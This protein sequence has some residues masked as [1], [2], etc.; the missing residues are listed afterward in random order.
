LESDYK[1][2]K[3]SFD[4]TTAPYDKWKDKLENDI[5]KFF[6]YEHY[7][8]PVYAK[9][10]KGKEILTEIEGWNKNELQ[11]ID[12]YKTQ[13]EAINKVYNDNVKTG[14]LD[15][16]SSWATADT[17]RTKYAAEATDVLLHDNLRDGGLLY[18]NVEGIV[19]LGHSSEETKVYVNNKEYPVA[20]DHN[21]DGTPTSGYDVL[22]ITVEGTD[23]KAIY[24]FAFTV[25]PAHYYT[26]DEQYPNG[27]PIDIVNN[28]FGVEWASSDY[29]NNVIQSQEHQEVPVG[30]G[31]FMATNYNND[32]RPTGDT[33]WASNAV[34]YKRNENFMFPVKTEKLRMQVISAANAIDNLKKGNVDYITPQFT[35]ANAQDLKEMKES[36][37]FNYLHAQQLGY[38]YIGINAGK[39]PDLEIRKAIMAAMQTSLALDYYEGGTCSNIMWP[40][41]Q[42]SWAYPWENKD[43]KTDKYNGHSYTIWDDNPGET[44]NAETEIKDLMNEI[45]VAEGDPRLT[46]EFTIAG[47]SIT[48]HPSYAVFKQAAKILNDLGWKVSVTADSQALTKLA[49]GSLAVWAAAWGSTVDPDM[50]Q[51][52]HMN[53]TATSVYSWGYREIKADQDTYWREFDIIERLSAKIDEARTYMTKADR[54][55]LYEEAMRLVLDLAVEMPVYQRETLYAYNTKTIRGLNESVNPYSTPLEKIWELE[56]VQ[57]E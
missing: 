26:A 28:K 42:V 51:V 11:L 16:L 40:M 53:S 49:T 2:A 56:L 10:N 50:Y 54:T 32:D 27:R 20:R 57:D 36:G 55:P 5:F 13:E 39:V 9:D 15:I 29:Q 30:A 33:F 52:Y 25:A 47:A 41:S 45:G 18:P 31:P 38:G 8:N 34:Y 24:S 4:L 22:Q 35:K 6:L 44:T 17:L 43:N 21:A 7:I 12:L 1:A 3:E 23:P 37:D 14:L 46:I 19:S 48:E